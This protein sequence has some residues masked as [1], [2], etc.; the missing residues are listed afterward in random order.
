MGTC[1]H[2][3]PVPGHARVSVGG[4]LCILQMKLLILLP[5]VV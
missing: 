3:A 5:K 1:E 4:F 2:Q